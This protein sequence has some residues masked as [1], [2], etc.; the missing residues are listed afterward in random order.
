MRNSF[1][2]LDGTSSGEVIIKR[3]PAQILAQILNSAK[4]QGLIEIP[5]CSTFAYRVVFIFI[6]FDNSRVRKVVGGSRAFR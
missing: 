3:A 1:Q 6:I 2:T 5:T 4:S